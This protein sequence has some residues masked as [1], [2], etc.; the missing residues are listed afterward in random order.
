MTSREAGPELR[1]LLIRLVEAGSILTREGSGLDRLDK[2]QRTMLARLGVRVGAL[3]LFLPAMLRPSALAAWRELHGGKA[4]APHPQMP[5]VLAATGGAPLTG[6]RAVGKQWLRLD[7]AEKL[8]RDAHSVR[9]AAGRRGF[10]LD[11]AKAVSMGLTTAGYARLLQLAGFQPSMPRQLRQGTFGPP[12][13]AIWR[14]RPPRRQPTPEAAP[15]R[16]A[17]GAFAALAELVR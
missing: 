1:A 4:A 16:K 14:W 8:L 13:P 12:A 9:I 7:M 10:T 6:Y 2:G 15:P 11:P 5:P 3:D 17:E